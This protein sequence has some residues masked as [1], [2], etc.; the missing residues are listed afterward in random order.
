M[1]LMVSGPTPLFVSFTVFAAVVDPANPVNFKLV[2]ANVTAGAAP[3][4]VIF[5]TWKLP[6]ASSVTVTCPVSVPETVG[7]N[8]TLIVHVPPGAIGLLLT[9]L[10]VSA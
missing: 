4:P 2:G 7:V 8:V 6:G 1:E 10:S 9:Q 5:T 3:A